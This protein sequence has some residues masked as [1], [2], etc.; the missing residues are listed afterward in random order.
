MIGYLISVYIGETAL[1]YGIS[2]Y[3]GR[4]RWY[5]MLLSLLWPICLCGIILV[6]IALIIDWWFNIDKRKE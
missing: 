6:V 1:I 3:K 2:R 5:A 4:K